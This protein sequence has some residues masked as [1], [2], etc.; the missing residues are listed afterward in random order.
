LRFGK[1]QQFPSE[2]RHLRDEKTGVVVHQ[3]TTHCSINHHLYFLNRSFTPDGKVIIFTSY[4]DGQPNL[5]E[6]NFPDGPIGQLTEGEGLHP[7]SACL[8]DSGTQI[9][10][11]RK[12]S[13]WSLDRG[14]LEEA[15]LASFSNA[16]LGECNL[17]HSGRWI[18]TAVRQDGQ[19]GIALIRTDGREHGIL[20]HWPRTVI[21]PQFHPLDDNLIE[22][23]SDPAPRMHLVRRDNGHTE[24]LYE[25]GNNEFIV[26]E[27]FLGPSGDLVFEVWPFALKRLDWQSREIS[28][29]AEINAWHIAPDSMGTTILYDTNHPDIG[30][31]RIEVASGKC[32]TVCFPKSSNQGSQWK[33][34][35]YAL[36]EDWARV[37]AQQNLERQSS[38]SW[39]EMKTDTVYGP[40]WTHPH[41]SWHPDETQVVFTSDR[42]GFPQ[43]YAARIPDNS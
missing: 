43:V 19:A 38:L 40:Q 20:L 2:H 25:H 26:H 16:Q 35:R 42:S 17:S 13:V 8:S 18:V 31:Q 24:C 9:F 32:Q 1:G 30:I 28:T 29:I 33:T 41:P 37:A 39:M 3:L 36:A 21:H 7:F 4:R 5:Y 14:T 34:S 22:F 27:T 11:T 15:C 23:S 10:F 12:G 6:S